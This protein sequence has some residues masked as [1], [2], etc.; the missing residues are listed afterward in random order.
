MSHLIMLAP[1]NYGSALAQ[2]GKGRLSRMKF[3]FGGVEPGQGVLDWLELGSEPS[4]RLNSG[5]IHGD[6]SQIGARGVF[7]FVLTGQS[8]DRAFYDN[9]NTYTGESGSDGVVRVAAANLNSRYV[10]LVQQKPVKAKR[11]KAGDPVEWVAP[12][13]EVKSVVQ[14]PE[15]ALR[16]V[17]GKSHSGKDMGIMRSVKSGVHDKKSRETVSA[18]LACIQVR[19]KTQYTKLVDRF[20]QETDKVQAREKLEVERHLLRSDTYFIHDR[21][22]MVVFRVHDQEGHAVKDYDLILTAGSENNPNH[23]PRGFFVDRQRNRVNPETITY[24]LNQDIMKGADE[25]RNEDGE[26]VRE[27]ILGAEMLGFRVIPRPDQGF[28]HY[29]PCEI[30]ASP[31]LLE[32]VLQPN[33]TTLV[34]ICLQRVVYKNVMRL[35]RGTKQGSFKRV[36]PGDE[37]V[38]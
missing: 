34:D 32:N 24:F 11:R 25:V 4:W 18:I 28:V 29:L 38:G 9:L 6:D 19:S 16:V 35:H 15:T 33:T 26:I 10:H 3:W 8:I 27:A 12:A 37:I 36:K 17:A 13:L 30:S 2:L 7:P 31:D 22:S 21:Y 1:A 14:G 23:L 5:W 20:A